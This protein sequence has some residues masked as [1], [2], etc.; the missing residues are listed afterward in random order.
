MIAAV[1]AGGYAKRLWPL[2]MNKPKALLPV[3]GKPVIEY[4]LQEIVTIRPPVSKIIVSTNLQ[5]QPAFEE[6]RKTSGYDDIIL[7]PDNSRSQAD[8]IGAIRALTNLIFSQPNEDFLVLAGDSIFCD[9]LSDFVQFFKKHNA[10]VVAVYKAR[11]VAEA[12]RGAVVSLDVHYR[13]E[14]CIEK[15]ENPKTS[16][17]G[18]CFYA[19]PSNIREKLETYLS[20]GLPQDQPGKF[21]EWLCNIEPVYAFMLQGPFLDIGTIES[22]QDAERFLKENADCR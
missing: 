14:E 5:F 20:L 13:I 8:K 12:R 4:L 1:L 21:V 2:S 15:P 7:V 16:L 6:W 11:N 17:I 3:A 9:R 18:A 10:P 22:Y 19:F